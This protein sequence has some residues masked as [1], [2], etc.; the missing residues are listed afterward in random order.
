VVIQTRKSPGSEPMRSVGLALLLV[1]APLATSLAVD[2]GSP[3]PVVPN[4]AN[5]VLDGVYT[6]TQRRS[7]MLTY[8][9]RCSSCHGERL[10]GG[11]SSPALSGRDFRQ[12]W[13]G[14]TLDDLMQKMML[15]PP[16]DAG[17]LTPEEEA[18]VIAVILAANGFP[19]GSEELSSAASRLQKIRIEQQRAR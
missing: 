17:T 15:M 18:S 13:D 1:G 14:R 16:N 6:E 10:H 3:K 7:G 8:L 2:L 12:R 11:E 9:K 5:S 4:Q 19:L